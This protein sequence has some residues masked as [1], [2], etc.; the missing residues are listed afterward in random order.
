MAFEP[1]HVSW[2]LAA[3]MGEPG[4]GCQIYQMTV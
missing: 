4:Q 3:E 2:T 1:L